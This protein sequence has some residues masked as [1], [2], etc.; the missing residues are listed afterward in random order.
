MVTD[1]NSNGAV[2]RNAFSH[3]IIIPVYIPEIGGYFKDSLTIL[4]YC[5]QS[6]FNT[7]HDKTYITVINNGS[8]SDVAAYLNQLYEDLKIHE[9]I[10][11]S[12]IGKLN[13][14]LKGIAGNQI[15]IKTISDSDVLF[16]EGWQQETSFLF[17]GFPKAGVVGLTPQFK[18]FEYNC[19]NLIVEN[20]FSSKIKFKAVKNPEAIERFYES[21]GWDKN[22]NPDYLK[23]QLTIKNK[24]AEAIIGSGHFV[25][26]YKADV[27]TEIISYLDCKL[28]GDTEWYL[29]STPLEKGYWRIT[30]LDNFAYHMGNV[31][32]DWMETLLSEQQNPIDV[33]SSSVDFRKRNRISYLEN[34]LKNRLFARLF[35]TPLF[36]KILYKKWGLPKAAIL[37][38]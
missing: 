38:Y 21:I 27:F 28:G 32:E 26:T 33:P 31:K 30:T 1:N 2:D 7:I 24:K 20:I 15:P 19:C 36:R 17:S 4:K 25:A 23:Y 8:C 16:C 35:S 9:V 6:L 22:Y 18:M 10:H 12:N 11:T 5:L 37:K 34:L 14:I 29:D 3:Q 13:A